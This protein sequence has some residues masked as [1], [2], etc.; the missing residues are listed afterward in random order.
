VVLVRQDSSYQK[1]ADLRGSIF[2]Y[3]DK[4]SL[5]GYY[6]MR[7]HLQTYY[8]ASES[9]SRSKPFFRN[10]LETGGH[11][12]S[13]EALLDG[14]AD[15]AAVDINVLRKL[16]RS[17]R[18]W[19]A[20]LKLLRQLEDVPELGPYPGQPFVVPASIDSE[21]REDIRGAL[22]SAGP[23]ELVPVGWKRIVP[24]GPDTYEEVR[25]MLEECNGN[26]LVCTKADYRLAS[27]SLGETR[28]KRRSGGA[29]GMRQR[30]GQ[31]KR[32]RC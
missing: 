14:R 31:K 15:V 23:R 30:G 2:A 3:N 19:R 16:R 13:L 11:L 6:C 29:K 4:N 18:P 7:F 17:S 32:L 21:L 27:P 8:K 10:A 5:S 26:D 24:V 28:E 12:R 22:L 20:K 1:F 25:R 9:S